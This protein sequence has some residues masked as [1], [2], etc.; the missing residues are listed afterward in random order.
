MA[1]AE[2][3]SCWRILAYLNLS[4]NGI[5]LDGAAAFIAGGLQFLTLLHELHLSN[6]SIDSHSA[7]A[8]AEG[9]QFCPI[10]HTL[11][12]TKN[13]IG[14]SGAIALAGGLQCKEMKYVNLSHN[15][16]DTESVEAL[17]TLVQ[18]SHLQTLDLSHNKIGS[19]GALCLVTE[20]ISN[21]HP[22]KLNLLMNNI[23]PKAIKFL[24]TLLCRN[25]L[26]LFRNDTHSF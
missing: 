14:S 4:D 3:L 24:S 17:A 20:L 13:T 25:P 15:N 23:S 1:V 18:S 26:S 8:L 10:L 22:T 16:I 19:T 6:N 9:I 2:R 5:I 7:I 11:A 12:I 21:V